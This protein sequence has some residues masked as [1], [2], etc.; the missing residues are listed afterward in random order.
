MARELEHGA[1]MGLQVSQAWGTPMPQ[2]T[3]ENLD[4]CPWNFGLC[5][6]KYSKMPLKMYVLK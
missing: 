1:S 5:L 3:W 6:I 2:Q 4:S